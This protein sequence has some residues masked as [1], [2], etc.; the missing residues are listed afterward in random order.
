MIETALTT[1]EDGRALAYDRAARVARAQRQ[2]PGSMQRALSAIINETDRVI[3]EASLNSL[4]LR[5]T[6]FS[7]WKELDDFPQ[8]SELTQLG[9]HLRELY[10]RWQTV[11]AD[12]RRDVEELASQGHALASTPLL[13]AAIAEVES[14]QQTLERDW[15][16]PHQ[17]YTKVDPE[18]IRKSRAAIASGDCDVFGVRQ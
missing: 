12:M 6:W 7:I 15:P 2:A 1:L 10:A 16:W 5:E 4:G 9:Q 8:F 17:P 3:K 13:H 14:L 18:M 11:L